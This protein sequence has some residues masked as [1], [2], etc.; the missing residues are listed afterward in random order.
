MS[1]IP[2]KVTKYSYREYECFP[3]DGFRHEIIDGEHYMSPAPATNHQKVSRRIQF[4]LYS[5]IELT[6]R[7]EVYD[8]PTDVELDTYDIVQP[9]ILV[10]MNDRKDIITRKKIKGVPHL[11]VEILS[12]SNPKNDQ[13]LKMEMYQRNGVQEYWIVDPLTQTILVLEL[14]NSTY[15][16]AGKFGINEIAS[17]RLLSG[18]AVAV[19]D[20]LN[21][22]V[23]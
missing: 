9:D 14:L 12:E 20:V 4:Q 1:T 19:N 8:A 11:V 16:V 10:V 6:G 22:P 3:D 17:S 18:F 15:E 7:G 5:Q 21:L 13:I 23:A 2:K